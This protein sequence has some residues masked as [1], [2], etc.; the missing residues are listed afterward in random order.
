MREMVMDDWAERMEQLAASERMRVVQGLLRGMGYVVVEAS[1]DENRPW[2]ERVTVPAGGGGDYVPRL[3]VGVANDS[4]VETELVELERFATGRGAG[5]RGM[6]VNL[7]GFSAAARERAAD[8][9]MPV[10]LLEAEDL[11]ERLRQHWSALDAE[12]QALLG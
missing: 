12:T 6:Y 10:M 2:L 1:E 5:D 11:A 9:P 8:L 3:V 7:A 4:T